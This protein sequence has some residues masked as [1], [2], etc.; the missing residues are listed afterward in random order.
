MQ[1]KKKKREVASKNIRKG[2]SQSGES[3]IIED[4]EVKYIPTQ[5][6]IEVEIRDIIRISPG[7]FSAL[8]DS[9]EEWAS[10]WN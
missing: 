2:L 6:K 5:Q 3:E 9:F 10:K 7:D 1:N 8:K 4:N